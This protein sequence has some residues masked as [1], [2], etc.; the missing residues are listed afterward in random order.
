MKKEH[1][2]LFDHYFLGFWERLNKNEKKKLTDE[3]K[4]AY[5]KKLFR[6]YSNLCKVLDYEES[7]IYT[8]NVPFLMINHYERDK[9]RKPRPVIEYFQKV[10]DYYLENDVSEYFACNHIFDKY[11]LNSIYEEDI[12]FRNTFRK[13]YKKTSNKNKYL[14]IT[15]YI[16]EKENR[17]HKNDRK[18]K[19]K[20]I[21]VNFSD[22]PFK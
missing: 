17:K 3:H 19:N 9:L 14:K 7:I 15:D 16:R 21:K 2:K 6:V 10:M 22:K 18:K 12:N 8:F 11:G 20:Y 1:K 4:S 5:E 13:W